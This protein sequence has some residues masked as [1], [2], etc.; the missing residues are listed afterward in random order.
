MEITVS[1]CVSLYKKFER[2]EENGNGRLTEPSL[3]TEGRQYGFSVFMY[4]SSTTSVVVS[5]KC[6]CSVHGGKEEFVDFVFSV[7]FLGSWFRHWCRVFLSFD[8]LCMSQLLIRHLFV[9][10]PLLCVRLLLLHRHGNVILC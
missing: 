3:Q 5:S 9:V 4:K 8:L 1:A 10:L 2:W 6:R 7:A